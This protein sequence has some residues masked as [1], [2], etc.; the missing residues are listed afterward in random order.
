MTCMDHSSEKHFDLRVALPIRQGTS[1][2]TSE[3]LIYAL[4]ADGVV[5]TI[6]VDTLWGEQPGSLPID[7]RSP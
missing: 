2:E 6:A 1:P 3:I 4:T 7:E 5:C